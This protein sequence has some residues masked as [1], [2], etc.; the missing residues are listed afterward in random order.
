MSLSQL[1]TILSPYYV[2]TYHSN[3]LHLCS[4]L[5]LRKV[6]TEMGEVVDE[7][8]LREL[9]AEVDLN[10]NNTIEE[11]EFLQVRTYK[12]IQVVGAWTH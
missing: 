3:L 5:D 9:I 6:L 8:Q 11:D 2:C 4:V 1:V 7:S 10:K 12:H